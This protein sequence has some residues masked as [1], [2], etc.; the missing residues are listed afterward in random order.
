MC[1]THPIAQPH[2]KHSTSSPTHLKKKKKWEGE[3][4]GKKKKERK[5]K[6]RKCKSLTF[7]LSGVELRVLSS[8]PYCNIL[9]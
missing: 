2:P 8:L 5:E 9:E 3:S 6:Q 7:P 1:S 4:E